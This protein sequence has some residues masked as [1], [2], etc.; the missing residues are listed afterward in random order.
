MFF[1]WLEILRENSP[2]SIRFATKLKRMAFVDP[3]NKYGTIPFFHLVWNDGKQQGKV[4][5]IK[6]LTGYPLRLSIENWELSK[7]WKQWSY[8]F[9]NRMSLS[10]DFVG[11][12]VY[13]NLI[14]FDFHRASCD[15]LISS[16][17]MMKY[18][19]NCST[20]NGMREKNA[21]LHLSNPTLPEL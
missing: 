15:S 6:C 13:I 19:F 7:K 12:I 17:S 11:F 9:L 18:K 21:A 10:A 2:Y 16:N 4:S 3:L 8:F 1:C 5:K 14:W 20:R